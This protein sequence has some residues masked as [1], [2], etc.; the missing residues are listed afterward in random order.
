MQALLLIIY[1]LIPCV[2]AAGGT[3]DAG[4]Y[5]FGGRGIIHFSPSKATHRIK[6]AKRKAAPRGQI[7]RKFSSHL[8]P[9]YW[10]AF[11][12]GGPEIRHAAT[13]LPTWSE[14]FLHA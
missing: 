10:S 6:R 4:G 1:I 3:Y 7:I 9:A 8:F 5:A 2:Q 13:C 11:G 14:V 12:H